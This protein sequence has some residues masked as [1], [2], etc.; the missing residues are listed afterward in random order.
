MEVSLISPYNALLS[1]KDLPVF[2]EENNY[3][4]I[5]FDEKIIIFFDQLS[6]SILSNKQINRIPEIVALAFWLRKANLIKMKEENSHLFTNKLYKVSPKGT[7]FHICP[8]NVDTMFIYS[9]AVSVLMGNKNILR[10]SNRMNAPHIRYLFELL[11][12]TIEHYTEFENYI[13]IINYEHNNE[14]SRYFSE[15]A[16]AR[17]IWGGDQTIEKIRKIDSAS[18]TKDIV[19]P[20]RISI[21]CVE[22]E[23]YNALAKEETGKFTKDFFNDAYTFD[24]KGCSSPQ[25]IFIVGEKTANEV[26]INNMQAALSDYVKNYYETDAAS[27]ASLKL[28]YI[29]DEAAESNN[30]TVT[31]SNLLT[32]M[33]RKEQSSLLQHTCGGGA[34]NIYSINTIDDLKKFISPKLQTISYFG[35]TPSNLE[36][37][38][39]L[40]NG[41]GIDR[42]VPMGTALEFYYLWDGYNLFDELCKKV[43]IRQ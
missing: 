2:R 31:G 7:V 14:I 17:I 10:V 39:N 25:S 26:C 27:I 28:N 16:A 5:P 41:E 20:D 11:N 32:F 6:K 9:L 12:K 8:A 37:L 33:F 40:S 13:N 23:K 24:Q 38:T 30:F 35:M 15:K 43:F 4:L 34:F 29:V 21:L 22:S 1:A 36:K 42:I 18:R 19:F 3:S